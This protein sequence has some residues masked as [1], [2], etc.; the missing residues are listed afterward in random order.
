MSGNEYDGLE[1]ADEIIEA[2]E[3]IA[4]GDAWDENSPAWK[5]WSAPKK[6]DFIE[7]E[8]YLDTYYP[9]WR[10]DGLNWGG[11]VTGN[12]RALRTMMSRRGRKSRRG[13]IS[14]SCRSPFWGGGKNV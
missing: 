3:S 14:L 6:L 10:K 1:T 11:D 13:Y 2:I 4:S 8:T 12:G 9:G 7:I 5:I